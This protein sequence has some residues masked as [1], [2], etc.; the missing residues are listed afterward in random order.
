MAVIA[1]G[2]KEFNASSA[3]DTEPWPLEEDTD[4]DVLRHLLDVESGAQSLVDDAQAEADRRTAETE[5]QNRA[6]YEE[7]YT[8][9]AALLDSRYE[10]EIKAVKA[11]Y[12]KL[13][14]EYRLE[15][16]ERRPDYGAFSC[17][18]DDFL[19]KDH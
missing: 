16:E 2:K 7:Q 19:E 3:G 17:L 11:E 15:L 14:D 6:R 9:E 12:D 1:K 13:L 10:V 4:R 8:K 5:K 18:L